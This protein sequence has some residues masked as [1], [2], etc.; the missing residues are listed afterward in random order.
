[1]SKCEHRY[2]HAERHNDGLWLVCR[3]CHRRLNKLERERMEA[4]ADEADRRLR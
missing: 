4:E 2:A 3:D 1:M